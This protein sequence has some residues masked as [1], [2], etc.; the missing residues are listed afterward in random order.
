MDPFHR[1]A[2]VDQQKHHL[3]QETEHETL[4]HVGYAVLSKRGRRA[5]VSGGARGWSC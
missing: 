4:A 2:S 3:E 1:V 5:V